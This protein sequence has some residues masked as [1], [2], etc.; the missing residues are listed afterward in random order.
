MSLQ[1]ALIQ[2]LDTGERIEVMYNPTEYTSSTRVVTA[3]VGSMV[4]FQRTESPTFTVHLFF[5]T[6][7]QGIDVRTLTR[8]VAALQQPTV[9]TGEQREPPTCVF[10]WGGF[11][12]TGIV[13]QLDQRFT[14]FL[15]SGVPVRAELTVT[16]QQ[17]LTARQANENAGLDN[18][19]KLH[20]VRQSDRLDLIAAQQLGDPNAW[21]RIATLN[22]IDDPLAFPTPAQIGMTL[23]I[24]D[25]DESAE[26]VS[27]AQN[28]RLS[29]ARSA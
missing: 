21:Q 4:Q 3:K 26:P 5:D 20:V 12:Y 10:S 14:M 17:I 27:P 19:R 1:K 25:R 9:G 6:Y 11:Q 23:I 22:N 8:K 15:P 16:F 28:G 29:R 7:E 24:P 2:N 18:C 13:T